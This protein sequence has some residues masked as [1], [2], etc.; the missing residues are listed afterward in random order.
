VNFN[1]DIFILNSLRKEDFFKD[2]KICDTA[3]IQPVIGWN[4]NL[5]LLRNMSIIKKHF[6]ARHVM[7]QKPSNWFSLQYG[8]RNS[9]RNL[10]HCLASG[11]HF[12][13]FYNFHLPQPTRKSTLEMLWEKE[14]ATLD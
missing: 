8:I 14:Y 11:S 6:I 7:L 3:L 2:G 13:G 1:D 9:I 12:S 5:V 4:F 10:L